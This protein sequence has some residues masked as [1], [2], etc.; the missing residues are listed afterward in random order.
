MGS[1]GD[2]LARIMEKTGT[3]QVDLARM[4]GVRQ[5]SISGFISGRVELSDDQ[6]DRLL[7]A[8][9]FSLE[10]RREAIPASL[11]HSE[12]CSWALHRRVSAH[13]NEK[14]L[15]QWSARLHHN[16]ERLRSGMRGVVHRRNID[17]WVV[18]I[19]EAD[20]NG[21]HRLLTGLDRHSIEMREVSPFGGI[22]DQN[23]RRAILDEMRRA[24]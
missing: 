21:M 12:L 11:T 16:I 14:S 4:T 5:P 8:M 17:S 3:S 13:L 15:T 9:G 7:S 10:V 24:G 1:R 19:N 6:L 20:I 2:L 23:E 18:L 22:L